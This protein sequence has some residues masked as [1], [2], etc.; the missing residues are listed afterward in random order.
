MPL[1]APENEVSDPMDVGLLCATA[2]VAATESPR[3]PAPAGGAD[4]RAGFHP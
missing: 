3:A 1:A 2:V 4:A